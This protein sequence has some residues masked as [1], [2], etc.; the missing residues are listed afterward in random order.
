MRRMMVLSIA[1]A[2]RMTPKKGIDPH[3][4]FLAT[5]CSEY[6]WIFKISMGDILVKSWTKKVLLENIKKLKPVYSLIPWVASI[7]GIVLS[8][9]W[10]SFHSFCSVC[11]WIYIPVYV[12]YFHICASASPRSRKRFLRS[13]SQRNTD[14]LTIIQTQFDGRYRDPSYLYLFTFLLPE[15]VK[16]RLLDHPDPEAA[17]DIENY[18][19]RASE[20][21]Q[22]NSGVH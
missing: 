16:S 9:C 4:G 2:E 22:R 21:W 19:S 18:I 5:T 3:V 13:R 17:G 12:P 8:F 10:F 7:S 15:P 11:L 1:I 20:L 14:N 6:W